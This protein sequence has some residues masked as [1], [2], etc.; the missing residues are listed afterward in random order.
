MELNKR[1]GEGEGRGQLASRD[2]GA[3]NGICFRQ[4]TPF[5]LPLGKKC[6]REQEPDV[7]LSRVVRIERGECWVGTGLLQSFPPRLKVLASTFEH[8]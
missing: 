4:H 2:A 5:S 8:D 3:R 1:R 7:A 6:E